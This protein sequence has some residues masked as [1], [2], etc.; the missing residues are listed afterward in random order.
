[1]VTT[2]RSGTALASRAKR[3]ALVERARKRLPEL[4]YRTMSMEGERIT[5]AQ[6][7]AAVRKAH[8]PA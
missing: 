4:V 6:A 2:K 1:M 8:V 3:Q 5:R 7:R